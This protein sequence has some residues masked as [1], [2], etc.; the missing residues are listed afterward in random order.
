MLKATGNYFVPE[1]KRKVRWGT[2]KYAAE[3]LAFGGKKR[4]LY[5]ALAL[6]FFNVNAVNKYYNNITIYKMYICACSC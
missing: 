2:K 1:Q 3:I 5:I 4:N 6:D